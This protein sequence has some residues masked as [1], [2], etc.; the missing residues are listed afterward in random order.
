MAGDVYCSVL[1][2]CQETFDL[3]RAYE[4]TTSLAKMV[5]VGSPIWCG[6][7]ASV[8]LYRAEVLQ[9]HGNWGRCRA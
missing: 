7:A 8:C 5:C 1:E 3:R 4:W 6:I 2:G 9:L